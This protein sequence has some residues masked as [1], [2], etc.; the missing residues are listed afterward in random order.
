[1][2]TLIT[3]WIIIVLSAALTAVALVR[4]S[5][6]QRHFGFLAWWGGSGGFFGFRFAASKTSMIHGLVMGLVFGLIVVFQENQ[7]SFA[8]VLAYALIVQLLLAIPM[9]VCDCRRSRTAVESNPGE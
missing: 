6:F 9:A 8:Q 1:M 5:W 2:H 3:G 4:Y 7:S